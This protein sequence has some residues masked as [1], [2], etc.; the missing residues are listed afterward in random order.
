MGLML[1]CGERTGDWLGLSVVVEGGVSHTEKVLRGWRNWRLP[2][3]CA[4]GE[5]EHGR[6]YGQYI[7]MYALIG[8]ENI[9]LCGF[10]ELDEAC[11]DGRDYI[12]TPLLKSE[13]PSPTTAIHHTPTKT[14]KHPTQ[15]Q[16]NN[17]KEG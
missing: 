8:T 16:I 11:D 1:G 14:T 3:L 5:G 13:D 15:T 2:I 9:L 10:E 17:I 4:R 12:Y 6:C 7:C